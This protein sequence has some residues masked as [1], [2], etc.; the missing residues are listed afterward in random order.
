MS[1]HKQATAQQAVLIPTANKFS[2]SEDD[3]RDVRYERRKAAQAFTRLERLADCGNTAVGQVYIGKSGGQA[4]FT[5]L[6]TCGSVWACSV[7]SAK[8]L[9]ARMTEVATALDAWS[10]KGGYFVFETLTMSH[11]KYDSLR[12][13][14]SAV[15]KAFTA[16]NGGGYAAKHSA[17]GQCGYLKVVEVTHGANGWHVHLHVLRFIQERL[18]ASKLNEWSDTI[19]AK[20]SS[21]LQK[22]GFK[23][24]NKAQHKFDLV[25]SP[26]GLERY[27][28]KSFDNSSVTA[29]NSQSPT[30]AQGGK[31]VWAVLDAA[32]ANPRSID[33]QVWFEWESGS[34]GKRQVSWSKNLRKTLGLNEAKNDEELAAEV[35]AFIPL[36]AIDA[37]SVRHLGRLGR[38]QS[39]VLRAVEKDDLSTA[40]HM[41]NEHGVVWWLTPEGIQLMNKPKDERMR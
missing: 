14:W 16:I 40:C 20:W 28:F 33:R 31:G 8:V 19:F 32:I 26:A 13:V 39:R 37:A 34:R 2:E 15:G 35:D 21:S 10:S 12:K 6:A 3:R 41:L 24:P 23:A 22:Q 17:Y 25:S 11:T 30:K 27:L 38:I 36:I 1:T 29:N 4:H 18:G 7:C 5:Q 9:A